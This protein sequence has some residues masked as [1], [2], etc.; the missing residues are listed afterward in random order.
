MVDG[1][2]EVKEIPLRVEPDDLVVD[3][4]LQPG[5]HE[6]GDQDDRLADG[7]HCFLL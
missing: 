5:A 3:P 1:L 2:G 4:P 6:A 7:W